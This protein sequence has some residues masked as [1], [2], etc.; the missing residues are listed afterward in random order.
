ME[1]FNIFPTTIYVD[2]MIDHESYKSNFYDV[3]HK[4]DY[5]ED[6]AVSENIGNPLIHHEDSLEELFSEVI[7]HV[8]TY[9]L[10]VLKYKNIFDYI[11]TKTWLSRSRDENSIP[12]H[13]H[14]CA[15]ISFVYYINV[16]PKSH[17]LKFMNPHFKNSLWLG[18]KEGKYDHLKMIQEH[19]AVNAET[20]FIHP[21]EGHIALFP[22]TLRHSTEYIKGFEG[23]RLAIVGDVTCVLKKEYLQFS[24]GFISPQYWKIYQG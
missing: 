11:I 19:D 8:K 14:A 21:P 20:F 12:W 16:P 5:E 9:T 15:H 18:N 6:D 10:D 24:T 23:E 2:K 17:K 1:V 7:S 3:Y 13:I 4:F 22:S